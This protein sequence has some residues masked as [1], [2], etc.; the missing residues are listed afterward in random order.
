[1]EQIPGGL[2]QN[3]SYGD[4]VPQYGAYGEF[5]RHGIPQRQR[6]FRASQPHTIFIHKDAHQFGNC[7]RR[8]RI[9]DMNCRHFRQRRERTV[10]PL[11]V[12][13]YALQ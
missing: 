5:V 11:M 2:E 8:V 6:R 4:S 12:G 7:K 10:A 3:F 9:V 13:Y 1:M